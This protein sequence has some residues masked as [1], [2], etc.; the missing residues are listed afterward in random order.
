MRRLR[1]KLRKKPLHILSMWMLLTSNCN[2]GSPYCCR[3]YTLIPH[4]F[5]YS[6]PPVINTR[7]LVQKK[8][9]LLE[10]LGEIEVAANIINNRSE[11]LEK[12]EC[13]SSLH[14]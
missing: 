8:F 6:L 4:D 1:K 5:G 10:T 12:M 7:E 13:K 2:R 14:N 3:F 11:E 9:E